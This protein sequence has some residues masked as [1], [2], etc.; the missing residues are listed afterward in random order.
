MSFKRTHLQ[1]ADAA[2]GKIVSTEEDDHLEKDLRCLEFSL[3]DAE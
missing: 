3:Y 1:C 2:I